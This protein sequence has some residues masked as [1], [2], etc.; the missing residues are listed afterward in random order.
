[1][2]SV[3]GVVFE[4]FGNFCFIV[5]LLTGCVDPKLSMGYVCLVWKIL[6]EN[7]ENVVSS[8]FLEYEWFRA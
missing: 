4:E 8:K 1:M 7:T 5:S 3:R 2:L 6:S